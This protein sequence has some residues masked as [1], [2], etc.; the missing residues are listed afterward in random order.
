[1]ILGLVDEAV[2]SGASQSAAIQLLVI[3]PRTLQR[4]RANGIGEDRRAGPREAPRNKLSPK[5]RAEV[6][7]VANCPEYR[8]LSPKQIVPRLADEGRY[9]A[10]ET[11]FYRVLRDEGQMV[12]REASRAPVGHNRPDELVATGPNQVWSWDI[13]YLRSPIRGAFF[14]LYVVLDVWS[15]KIVGWDVHEEESAEHASALIEAACAREGVERGQLALHSD[16]GGPMKAATLLAMLEILGVAASFSRPRV[17]NDNPYSESLFRTAKYRPQY[18]RRP[19]KSLDEARSWVA[20]FVR[21]YN[22][23]HRHSA[24]RFVTPNERHSGRDVE[25][26]AQR[27]ELYAAARE[28][29]PERW[30]GSTRDWTPVREVVLNPASSTPAEVAA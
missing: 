3:Y 2:A 21:W 24:I 7:E 6:L 10:S 15:R 13:T 22:S 20:Y 25:I 28:R 14:Y 12:H 9:L 19:F 29:R 27:A 23:E 8:D 11:T 1:M 26:L 16:N 4:W 17:S 18:P 5:E 30:T